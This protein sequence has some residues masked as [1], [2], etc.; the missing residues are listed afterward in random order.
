MSAD[1]TLAQRVKLYQNPDA[2]IVLSLILSGEISV[3]SPHPDIVYKTRYP[4]LEKKAH[5]PPDRLDTILKELASAGI[6]TR[7]LSTNI[8][9][10]P[11][12]HSFRMILY[13]LC[14]QCKSKELVRN[15][16]YEHIACGQIGLE[17]LFTVEEKLKCPKC[18]ADF[19]EIGVDYRVAGILYQ[20]R[21]CRRSFDIPAFECGCQECGHTYFLPD[22]TLSPLFE[23]TFNEAYRDEALKHVVSLEPILKALH[24]LGVRAETPGR[25]MG[26]SGVEQK[27]DIVVRRSPTSYSVIDIAS[28]TEIPP[29]NV[30]SL[31]A[32]SADVKPE[33]AILIAIPKL[34][35]DARPLL[36]AYNLECIESKTVDEAAA[37]LKKILKS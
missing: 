17:Q 35:S 24:E 34:R 21:S 23:Y 25:V 6:L 10:C 11:F 8:L 1:A 12:C 15:T 20:C 14:P 7:E 3:I 18:R 2:R 19:K 22:A 37:A 28:G 29:E 30:L 4:V 16:V 27:F 5:L 33:K 36:K 31:F 13:P 32:K 9:V 26:M